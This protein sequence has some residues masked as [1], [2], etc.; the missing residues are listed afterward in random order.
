MLSSVYFHRVD[1]STVRSEYSNRYVVTDVFLAE[2]KLSRPLLP[3]LATLMNP[4]TSSLRILKVIFRTVWIVLL[5]FLS[6][7]LRSVKRISV[8]N[9]NILYHHGRAL[10]TCESGPPMRVLLPYLQTVGWFDGLHA[11]GEPEKDRKSIPNPGF[12]G[13]GLLGAFREWT[14]AHVSTKIISKP[15]GATNDAN[16]G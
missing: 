1:D 6:R 5:S 15:S 11:E 16:L 2:S 4:N 3:S 12:T 10:A 13:G 9:T 8:A 14:T 7:S